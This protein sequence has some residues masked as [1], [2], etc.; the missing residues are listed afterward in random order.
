[1]APAPTTADFKKARRGIS[2]SLIKSLC[3]RSQY[4][5]GFGMVTLLCA[6]G[7]G[8]ARAH[9]SI[10]T[11]TPK[12]QND[13]SAKRPVVNCQQNLNPGVV[14]GGLKRQSDSGVGPAGFDPDA[15]VCRGRDT[16]RFC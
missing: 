3:S 14:K 7:L 11:F 2:R 8:H 15:F 1:M 13:V 16:N 6:P 12:V 9:R 4:T 10:V 5:I